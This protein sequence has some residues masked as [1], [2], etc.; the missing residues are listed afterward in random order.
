[1]LTCN[2]LLCICLQLLTQLALTV[3]ELRLHRPRL[4][5]D[6]ASAYAHYCYFANLYLGLYCNFAPASASV[7]YLSACV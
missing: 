1:M 5:P 3:L 7:P 4:V 2:L 6:L